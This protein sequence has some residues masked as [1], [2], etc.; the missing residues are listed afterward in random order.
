MATI[1]EVKPID[2]I[3]TKDSKS[4]MLMFFGIMREKKE[5]EM[6]KAMKEVADGKYKVKSFKRQLREIEKNIAK[7][8][9]GKPIPIPLPPVAMIPQ[10]QPVKLDPYYTDTDTKKNTPSVL[11][12]TSLFINKS[13]YD[14]PD[15]QV[16]NHDWRCSKCDHPP[17][18]SR[19]LLKL[20]ISEIHS[21]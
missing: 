4:E 8:K 2:R 18:T 15:R 1:L 20:H 12:K 6:L 17:F 11:V 9:E 10:P 13:T 3:T 19:K 7:L 14:I 5:Y 21:Y 16:Y